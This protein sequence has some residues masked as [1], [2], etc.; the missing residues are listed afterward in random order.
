MNL[1]TK[2]LLISLGWLFIGF[3]WGLLVGLW[4]R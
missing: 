3:D 1:T 2:W 4:I